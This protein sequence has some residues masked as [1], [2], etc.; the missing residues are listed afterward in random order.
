MVAM[1]LARPEPHIDV[2]AA[3][4][5][6]ARSISEGT[7]FYTQRLV[8]TPPDH[9]QQGF[10]YLP[11]T[12]LA[13]YPFWL[14]FGDVRYGLIAALLATAVI[15]YLLAGPRRGL[16]LAPLVV[17]FPRMCFSIAESWTEPLLLFALAAMVLATRR[18]RPGL[19]TAALAFA[20]ATKQYAVLV[21]PLAGWWRAFGWR[22]TAVAAG[23]AACVTVPWVAA[24]TQAFLEG[25]V[26]YNLDE[27]PRPDALS[28]SGLAVRAGE[29]VPVALAVATMLAATAVA[30]A[31]LPRSAAGFALAAAFVLGAFD[32]V[33][34]I[35]F[36]NHW[37]LVLGL[38][39]LALATRADEVA[40]QDHQVSPPFDTRETS[41]AVS[42]SSV[43]PRP[44]R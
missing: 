36:L 27:P 17:L 30:C 38:V 25:A 29:T 1:T 14:L 10:P 12:A 18:G 11:G 28:L 6:S 24:D 41:G 15:V 26:R 42:P 5:G 3:L 40:E 39:L 32:L 4:Q 33:N 23:V 19:A 34:K 7:N 37:S 21:V 9:L 2:W 16:L 20:L 31:R 35:S 8:N 13:L 43:L 22:R 44:R